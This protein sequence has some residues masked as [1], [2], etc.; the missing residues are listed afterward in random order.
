MSLVT[1]TVDDVRARFPE[2]DEGQKPFTETLIQDALVLL[3][4]RFPLMRSWLETGAV[5]PDLVKWL[6]V[7]AV[8]R[9]LRNEAVGGYESESDDGYSYRVGARAAS[10]GLWWPDDEVSLL[11]GGQSKDTRR[12]VR[13]GSIRLVSPGLYRGG[14]YRGGGW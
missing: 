4:A 6:V 9:V 10:A 3:A 8:L 2:Y 5:S 14:A 13:A 1:V 12:S 7:Q 11:P